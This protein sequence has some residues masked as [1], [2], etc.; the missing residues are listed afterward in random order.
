VF[1]KWSWTFERIHKSKQ[2][3]GVT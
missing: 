1:E 3:A 2:K